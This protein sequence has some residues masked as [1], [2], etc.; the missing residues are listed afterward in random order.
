MAEIHDNLASRDLKS[1]VTE[2]L[3]IPQGEKR[4]RFY[5]AADIL[6][7]IRARTRETRRVADPFSEEASDG[8]P[9]R[10]RSAGL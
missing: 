3:L 1:L 7:A 8:A 10:G 6:K 9:P 4:G 5:V 2:G